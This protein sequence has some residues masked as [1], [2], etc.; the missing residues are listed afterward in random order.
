MAL[1]V[2]EWQ[3]KPLRGKVSTH[4]IIAIMA[5]RVAWWASWNVAAV[6]KTWVSIDQKACKSITS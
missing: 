1:T 3:H 6:A 2:P 4:A 5:A